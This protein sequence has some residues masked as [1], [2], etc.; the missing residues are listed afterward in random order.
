MYLAQVS[1]LGIKI[2]NYAVFILLF[3]LVIKCIKEV[4]NKIDAKQTKE[5]KAREEKIK[6]LQEESKGDKE[7]LTEKIYK[8]YQDSN[9]NPILYYFIKISVFVL[10]FALISVMVATFKPM[11]NFNMISEDSIQ[12]IVSIY[13][14]QEGK[15][16][17]NYTEIRLLQDLEEYENLYKS[18]GVSEEEL[19]TLYDLKDSFDL[20]GMQTYIVPDFNN[21]SPEMVF[22]LIAFMLFIINTLIALIKQCSSLKRIFKEGTL[23][24][25][26][27][28]LIA[29]GLLVLSTI[30]VCTFIFNTPIVISFY[31]IINYAWNLMKNIIKIVVNKNSKKIEEGKINETKSSIA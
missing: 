12:S 11:T 24:Q 26:A 4:F 25:K 17:K 18:S 5:K 3:C 29:P 13:K 28:S 1:L 23:T 10:D 15:S 8:F 6:K 31:F 21:Y 2:Q 9:Y 22:P 7:L 20:F 30:L 27:L 19:E 16:A 14:E